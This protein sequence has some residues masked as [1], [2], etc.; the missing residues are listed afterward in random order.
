MLA[1]AVDATTILGGLLV[2]GGAIAI[3]WN[4]WG[5]RRSRKSALEGI[6][7]LDE[8]GFHPPKTQA[9]SINDAPTVEVPALIETDVA[10]EPSTDVSKAPPPRKRSS[11]LGLGSLSNRKPAAPSGSHPSQI[12]P[13][14]NLEYVGQ[15]A[16]A[17]VYKAVDTRDQRVVALKLILPAHQRDEEFQKRF[18]RESDISI[19]LNHPNVVRVFEVGEYDGK[20]LM[21]ME[22]IDGAALDVMIDEGEMPLSQ[23]VRISSQLLDGLHYAHQRDLVHRDIKPHNILVTHNGIPKLLDFGLALGQGMDRFTTVGASMG[24]PTH[25]APETLT[26]GN[27]DKKSDQYA[28]GVVLFQMI[29]GQCPFLGSNPMQIAMQHVKTPPPSL[30]SLRSDTPERLEKIV[31]RMLKKDPA[32]RYPTLTQIKMEMLAAV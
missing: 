22:Y 1:V 28:M 16:M 30:R 3:A 32:E 11:S 6:A 19:S 31:L 24:T 26:T 18:R 5:S 15:G 10:V 4:L 2:G 20:L 8:E 23:M 25:M 17:T 12:G 7:T 9:P 21:S 14:Q 29:T 27:S 13:F